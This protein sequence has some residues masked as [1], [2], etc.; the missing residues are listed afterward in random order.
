VTNTEQ[1]GLLIGILALFATAL[2]I[3]ITVGMALG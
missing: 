3:G 2:A 1:L